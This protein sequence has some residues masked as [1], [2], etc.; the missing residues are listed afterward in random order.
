MT[1]KDN[2]KSGH[3]STGYIDPVTCFFFFNLSFLKSKIFSKYQQ[4]EK[5]KT[6]TKFLTTPP[7]K[8]KKNNNNINKNNI[9][10]PF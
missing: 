8:K 2:E 6:Q 10:P 9:Q 5:D 4:Q 7:K 1:K 3:L